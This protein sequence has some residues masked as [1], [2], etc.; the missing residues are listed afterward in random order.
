[1]IARIAQVELNISK[2]I[3]PDR[4]DSSF[5]VAH[6]VPDASSATGAVFQRMSQSLRQKFCGIR[7]AIAIHYSLYASFNIM[8][9]LLIF[10][11][12]HLRPNGIV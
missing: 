10:F 1:M 5:A 3:A 2:P 9:E 6:K 12:H 11:C 7:C 4:V 8:A